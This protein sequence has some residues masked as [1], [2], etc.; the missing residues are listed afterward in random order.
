M[1]RITAFVALVALC[2]V[3]LVNHASRASIAAPVAAQCEDGT[4][5]RSKARQG[6]CARHGGVK[7]WTK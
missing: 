7:T 3:L 1:I 4:L 5:S 2:V 6:T